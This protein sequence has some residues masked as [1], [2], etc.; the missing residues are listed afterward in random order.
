MAPVFACKNECTAQLVETYQVSALELHLHP[1][2]VEAEVGLRADGLHRRRRAG[3]F[4]E[5]SV[6]LL[7]IQETGN[8][9]IVH[10]EVA[11]VH[12]GIRCGTPGKARGSTVFCRKC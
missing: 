3:R 12:S 4:L 7:S 9:S 10:D 11:F 2:L 6:F 1:A 8:S 5:D